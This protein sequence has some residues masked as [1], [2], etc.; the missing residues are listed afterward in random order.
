MLKRSSGGN[1][2]SASNRSNQAG[3]LPWLK[4]ENVVSEPRA[5]SILAARAED[6][7]WGN[8]SVVVKLRYDGK[9]YL[10]QPNVKNPC[11]DSLIDI[12]GGD[13]SKWAG[14]EV[15]IFCEQDQVTDRYYLRVK[16][17]TKTRK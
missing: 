11:F 3:G 15:L 12:L 16:A 8:N 14:N 7:R 6:D 2:A 9:L 1:G 17:A 10:W 13:E 5:A 4:A